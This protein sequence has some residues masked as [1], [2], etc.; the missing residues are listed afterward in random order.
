[1]VAVGVD[2]WD[3]AT[4]V[5]CEESAAEEVAVEDLAANAEVAVLEVEVPTVVGPEVADDSTAAV[6]VLNDVSV[7]QVLE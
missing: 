1:M 4:S 7:C 6:P 2:V 5:G 3:E